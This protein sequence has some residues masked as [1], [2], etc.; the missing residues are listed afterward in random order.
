MPVREVVLDNKTGLPEVK[1]SRSEEGQMTFRV[2]M[3]APGG[4]SV[5][6]PISDGLLRQM[7]ED[8]ANSED[9]HSWEDEIK[10]VQ[11]AYAASL[12]NAVGETVQRVADLEAENAALATVADAA[13]EEAERERER[14]IA[15]EAQLA[16]ARRTASRP[17]GT[18][19]AT[20]ASASA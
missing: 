9:D 14:A 20:G 3:I 8:F 4:M 19:Q 6:Q 11:R 7:R 15:L 12:R 13:R 2:H 1:A 10:A 18:K 17:K 16:E 5:Y